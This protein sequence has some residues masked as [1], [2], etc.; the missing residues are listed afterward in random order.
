MSSPFIDIFVWFNS[1]SAGTHRKA[2]GIINPSMMQ[3]GEVPD[4]SRD[5]RAILLCKPW[6]IIRDNLVYYNGEHLRKVKGR[7]NSNCSTTNT[8]A[9]HYYYLTPPL[10]RRSSNFQGTS[11]VCP[12]TPVLYRQIIFFD[13]LKGSRQNKWKIPYFTLQF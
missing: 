9:Q 7:F 3:R 13:T 11:S 12:A 5:P 1:I 2:V 8:A 6:N 4:I 10:P